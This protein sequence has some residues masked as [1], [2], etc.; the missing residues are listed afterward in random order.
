MGVNS[1]PRQST[2]CRASGLKGAQNS[3]GHLVLDMSSSTHKSQPPTEKTYGLDSLP[4]MPFP[5]YNGAVKSSTARA[6]QPTRL[7]C[8]QASDYPFIRLPDLS[9]MPSEDID[10][11][12][13]QG[14][15]QLPP[16][17]ILD[18][19]VRQYFLHVHPIMPLLDEGHFWD[20]YC[21]RLGDGPEIERIPMVLFQAMLF[22]SCSVR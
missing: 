3:P 11:L 14:C 19:F 18:E 12:S 20:I 13:L 1:S 2:N 7:D 21:D 16:R 5:Q 4:I 10:C 9:K 15:L 22:V 8:L 17:L 6:S